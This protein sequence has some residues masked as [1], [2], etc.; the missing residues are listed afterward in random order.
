[1]IATGPINRPVETPKA[2]PSDV[3]SAR[4]LCYVSHPHRAQMANQPSTALTISFLA[5]RRFGGGRPCGQ[6][7]KTGPVRA[8]FDYHEGVIRSNFVLFFSA[9]SRLARLGRGMIG[10]AALPTGPIV[11]ALAP[12]FA[13]VVGTDVM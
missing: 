11:G 13:V 4:R 10:P 12:Q 7:A 9:G 2:G 6:A 8:R 5:N 1:M 3:G